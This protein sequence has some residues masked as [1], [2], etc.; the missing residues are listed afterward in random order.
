MFIS[1]R[2]TR[3]SNANEGQGHISQKLGQK[4][5][6]S[7]FQ[8]NFDAVFPRALEPSPMFMTSFKYENKVKV[9]GHG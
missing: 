7:I 2:S 3:N 1:I 6:F 5:Q 4:L 9:I 8:N